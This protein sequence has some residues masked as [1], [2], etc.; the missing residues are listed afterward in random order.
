MGQQ[1][2]KEQVLF[3]EILYS[4]LHGQGCKS[5]LEHFLSHVQEVSPWF[6]DE[7]TIDLKT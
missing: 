4:M 6:P 5:Q 2:S 1:E 7:R 3:T